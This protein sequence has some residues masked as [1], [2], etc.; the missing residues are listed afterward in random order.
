MIGQ[1]QLHGLEALEKHRIQTPSLTRRGTHDQGNP[2]RQPRQEASPGYHTKL[3]TFMPPIDH[4]LCQPARLVSFED[5]TRMNSGAVDRFQGTGHR[6]MSA[7]ATQSVLL[8]DATIV[9]F[10]PHMS[11][12]L[13]RRSSRKT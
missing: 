7:N 5:D 3:A 2:P 4:S 1:P 9:R 8:S 6:L 11:Q 10:P 12:Q 13:F